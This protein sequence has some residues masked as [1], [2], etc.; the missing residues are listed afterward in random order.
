MNDELRIRDRKPIR[1]CERDDDGDGN[2]PIHSAPG[3][4]RNPAFNRGKADVLV[5]VEMMT[6]FAN[7]MQS[8]FGS[9]PGG[10]A[11]G[12]A[13]V[14]CWQRDNSRAPNDREFG[15][16]IKI[17]HDADPHKWEAMREWDRA[18]ILC[19]EWMRHAYE[20]P[21]K[22]EPHAYAAPP[23]IRDAGLLAGEGLFS[24]R[25]KPVAIWN[26]DGLIPWPRGKA[27]PE[28]PAEIKDLLYTNAYPCEISAEQAD[29]NMEA[30]NQ[31]ILEAYRRGLKEGEK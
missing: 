29:V 5:P 18:I 13:A 11:V 9:V 1:C 7:A 19:S 8:R 22:P 16:M 15:E 10:C 12:V 20:A 17:C 30:A 21:P 4:F 2:C 31:R 26:G 3:V 25:G 28:V 24:S 27:E 6:A 14:L 23:F